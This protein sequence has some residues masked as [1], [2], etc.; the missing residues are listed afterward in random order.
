MPIYEYACP[1]CR[2]IFSFLVRN[3]STHRVPKCPDCGAAGMRRAIS[4]FRVGRSEESRIEKLADPSA[5]AGF[6]E[7]DPK[8]IARLMKKM[9]GELGEDMPGD[10]DEMAERLEAG[11]NPEQIEGEGG[12]DGFSRDDSGELYEG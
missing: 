7:N 11:E 5:L 4:S 3:V 1:H 2:R 9:G 8:S 10:I 6:D 12:V